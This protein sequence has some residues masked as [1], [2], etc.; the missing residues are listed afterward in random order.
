M[1]A[2]NSVASD[3][4]F[5]GGSFLRV[6]TRAHHR[7]RNALTGGDP[8]INLCYVGH[9]APSQALRRSVVVVRAREP[10][11]EAIQREPI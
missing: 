8:P 2:V 5:P 6:G 10:P 3:G 7:D 11:Q 4:G 9:P 1:S